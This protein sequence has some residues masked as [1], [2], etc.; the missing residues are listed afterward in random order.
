VEGTRA[1]RLLLVGTVVLLVIRLVLVL[2][3]TG[4]LVV[5]D[6]AGYLMNARAL[7]GGVRGQLEAAPFYRGGYSLLI[8]PLVAIFS[9]PVTAYRLI[10]VLNV[11][12][13]AAVAP[14]L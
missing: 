4:P 7:T 12:L 9:D 14:L 2:F 5:A 3:R 11:V 13:A 1:R 6:E 8:A 10:L